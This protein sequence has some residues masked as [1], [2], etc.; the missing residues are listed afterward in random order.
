MKELHQEGKILE[1]GHLR[2]EHVYRL[3][4]TCYISGRCDRGSEYNM[5]WREPEEEILPTWRS[6]VSGLFRIVLSPEVFS[7][8]C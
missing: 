2:T 3:A 4:G 6:L 8:M 7:Q 5:M 1:L